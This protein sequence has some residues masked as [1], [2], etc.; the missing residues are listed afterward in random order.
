VSAEA[1]E[2][3]IVEAAQRLFRERGYV[4]TTVE[5]LAV[6]AG[7]A[8]QTIYNSIGA[9]RA[10][11][12][13]VIDYVAAGPEAPTPVPVFMRQRTEAAASVNEIVELLADW[14]VDANGRTAEVWEVVHQAA[15]MDRDV[16]QLERERS[17]QRLRN[18]TEAAGLIARAG[19]LAGLGEPEAAATIWTLGHPLVRRFLI[20]D[21]GW[22]EERYRT[23]L[24]EGLSRLV[25]GS[26]D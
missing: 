19:G 5:D 21:E 13:R 18:Y 23:W 17:R 9:K 14:F 16:A 26:R 7:V 6:E 1:T 8:V 20:V 25:I 12:S 24:V 10:V 4:A 11:L 2:R 15:A 22:S 3:A